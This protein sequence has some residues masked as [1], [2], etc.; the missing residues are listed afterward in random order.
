MRSLG[1]LLLLIVT[2]TLAITFT[3]EALAA[4]NLR[5]IANIRGPEITGRLAMVEKPGGVVEVK[6]LLNGAPKV[7]TPGLHGLHLHE[8]GSCD[9]TTPMR[10][11]SAKGHFDPGP[12]GSSTPV[13]Q[14]HPYHLGDLPNLN[15]NARGVGKL[16]TF[17]TRISLSSSPVSVF[18]A[19]NT[20][21]IV[22]QNPD[23]FKA[24]GTASEAG[25]GRLACGVLQKA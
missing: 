18:D 20:A 24:G 11:S 17:T 1:L 3:P 7:L 19:D 10:F 23:L 22:H 13:E 2:F 5:A 15:V 16:Q 4:R 6:V 25:G 12:Y 21:I 9:Q 14:N 8:V